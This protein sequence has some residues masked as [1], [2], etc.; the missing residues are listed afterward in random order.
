M[1][2]LITPLII[3][4]LISY[5]NYSSAQW[6]QT[7][8]PAGVEITDII[9]SNAD[10]FASTSAGIYHSTNGGGTWQ[11][12]GL[13]TER[14]SCLELNSS[15]LF[16]GTYDG[17]IFRSSNNG[18]TWESVGL[19]NFDIFDLISHG[20]DLFAA[21]GGGA[22]Q[23]SSNNGNSWI[24]LTNGISNYWM[25]SLF[26][27]DTYLFAGG[28]GGIYRS[29]NNGN[30]WT[31]I[32]N[33]LPEGMHVANFAMHGG[34]LFAAGIE[35]G[36][37]Y[38]S[39][40]NGDSWTSSN[41]GL[42]PYIFAL[43]GNDLILFAGFFNGGVW[44]ST[45]NGD[46]WENFNQNFTDPYVTSFFIDDNFLYAGTSGNSLWLI[47]YNILPVELSSFTANVIRNTVTL[48]WTTASEINNSGFEIERKNIP[49][50]NLGEWTRVGFVPGNGTTFTPQDY[51]YTERVNTGKY[52]YRLKQIDLNGNYE[53]HALVNEVQIGIE[54]NYKLSQNYP[55]PFNPSTKID[56]ELPE[57]GKVNI[58]LYNL[59]GKELRTILNEYNTAGYF[60]IEFNAGEIAS[61][62]YVYRLE[63]NGIL[64]DS[65]Q[66]ILLK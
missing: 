18:L 16:G 4:F 25:Y 33:G 58:K 7:N 50:S 52:N 64:K 29:S 43:A 27:K 45:N 23:R 54:K 66:M 13:Q 6:Y 20:S 47:E 46:S 39:T 48:N 15:Y 11:L 61:G 10:Y 62:V 42:P 53:Y 2:K 44:E 51:Q 57:D 63:V 60:T 3:I 38:R 36:G 28:L 40:N 24:T 26:S 14:F 22:V 21:T 65:K 32:N 30:N 5:N 8:G 37:L 59:A 41:N 31:S 56:Y 9:I 49:S 55:N 17:G 12:I 1:K 19:A 34:T 35:T